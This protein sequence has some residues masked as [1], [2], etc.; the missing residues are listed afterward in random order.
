[1]DMG[2]TEERMPTIRSTSQHS[3]GCIGSNSPFKHQV[4]KKI[5]FHYIALPNRHG[6]GTAPKLP[7]EEIYECTI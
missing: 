4:V 3:L 7:A 6:K 1:M 2:A 5:C